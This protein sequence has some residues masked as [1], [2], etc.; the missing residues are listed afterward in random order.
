LV[1]MF[2]HHLTSDHVVQSSEKGKPLRTP[3]SALEVR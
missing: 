3:A 2:K 1:T